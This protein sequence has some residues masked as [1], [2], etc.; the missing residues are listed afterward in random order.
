[1][2]PVFQ[3]AAALLLF[4]GL[5]SSARGAPRAAKEVL[6]PQQV[7][8]CKVIRQAWQG[9]APLLRRARQERRQAALARLRDQMD[10]LRRKRDE[11]IDA[12]LGPTEYRFTE[13]RLRVRS[14]G[15]SGQIGKGRIVV[16]AGTPCLTDSAMTLEMPYTG[17]FHEWIARSGPDD[18]ITVSG[19]FLRWPQRPGEPAGGL[20][21]S[22]DRDDAMSNP[23]YRASVDS[24]GGPGTGRAATSAPGRTDGSPATRPPG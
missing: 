15:T 9:Y 23:E 13:W 10:A 20:E 1:M 24:V 12:L 14:V 19:T 6:P 4:A 16:A 3:G 21:G 5:A 8:F 17:P 2:G 11:Q 22:S 18:L 7:E